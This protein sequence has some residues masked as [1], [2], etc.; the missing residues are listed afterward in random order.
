MT[1]RRQ[2]IRRFMGVVAVLSVIVSCQPVPN[3][4]D[5]SST[6][7]EDRDR[8]YT[9]ADW[10]FSIAPIDSLWSVSA[11]QIFGIRETNVLSPIQVIMQRSNP[12]QPSQPSLLLNSFGRFEGEALEG[13]AALFEAH[14]MRDFVNYNQQGERIS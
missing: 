4:P 3:G 7:T 14:Y 1:E 5:E 9:N 13:I 10:G 11:S 8:T 2:R 12:G 6:G